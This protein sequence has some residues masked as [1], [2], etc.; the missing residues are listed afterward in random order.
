MTQLFQKANIDYQPLVTYIKWFTDCGSP[1]FNSIQLPPIQRNA[2][3]DPNQIEK[4]WDSVL[5]GFPIGSFLLAIRNKEQNARDLITGKQFPS[6]SQGYFLL[7]GQQR[8]RSLMLGFKPNME[9]R[10][11]IDLNPVLDFGNPEFND[12]KF[13][14]RLITKYQPWGMNDRTPTD[15]VNENEKYNAR[16][17]LHQTSVRYDYNVSINNRL[18]KY[19]SSEKFSW[20]IKATLPVPLD[21]LVSLCGGLSG[22][23]RRPDW[24]EVLQLIPERYRQEEVPAPTAH[25]EELLTSLELLLNNDEQKGNITAVAFLKQNLDI[26]P[27]A[28]DHKIQ[29]PMEVL[30]RRINANGTPLAGEE[31]AYSLLKSSWDEAYELVSRIVNDKKIGYLFSST[32]V[33]MAA[34]RMARFDMDNKDDPQPNGSDFRRWIG[35]KQEDSTSPFLIKMKMLISS[36]MQDRS[37]HQILNRFCDLVLYNHTADRKDI[38]IPKKLLLSLKPSLVHPILIWLYK[39]ADHPEHDRQNRKAVLRYILFSLFCINAQEKDKA[40]REAVEII[41]TTNGV[42]PDKDIYETWLEEEWVERLPGISDFNK[43]LQL[44]ADGLLRPW[45][46]V[47]GEESDPYRGFRH[48]FW[49]NKEL[50]LWFQREYHAEWFAGYNPMSRDAYDTPYDYDH[51]LPKSH[52]ITSG[53]NF[54]YHIDNQAGHD[55]FHGARSLY[56]NAIGNYRAWPAWANRSDNNK[57][58]TEKLRYYGVEDDETAC[59]LRLNDN[60]AFLAAS[61]IPRNDIELWRNAKGSPRDWPADR[62]IAWQQAVENRVKYLYYVLFTELGFSNWISN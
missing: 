3:W 61:A 50:L 38:G 15:K 45:H 12:R 40:S 4:L 59:E 37:F 2:V 52:L 23:Y 1:D 49:N 11:W 21:A 33:V 47:M 19:D 16:Y 27:T 54:S 53:G 31:M 62:R 8:T 5:R 20:P 41:R 58:H 42:F 17:E 26:V 25:F 22:T 6:E 35:E 24:D 29:D 43:T 44:P 57:C 56:V 30:F 36:G 7:D 28:Q 10:L 51:I 13:L 46:E 60:S 48:H 55:R 18:D 32:G 39:N 34:A 14:L 9:S